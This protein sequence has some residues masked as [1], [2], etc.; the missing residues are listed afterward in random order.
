MEL[1]VGVAR[2]WDGSRRLGARCDGWLRHVF[3]RLGQF[4]VAWDF[5]EA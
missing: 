1:V 4:E 3:F 2:Q 5:P